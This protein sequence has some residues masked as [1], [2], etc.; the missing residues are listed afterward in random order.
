MNFPSKGKFSPLGD[1]F[2]L[3]I[4]VPFPPNGQF[5]HEMKG[6]RK[7][8]FMAHEKIYYDF[9]PRGKIY[10]KP[11]FFA[12]KD[13]MGRLYMYGQNGVDLSFSPCFAC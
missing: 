3:L 10:L 8:V 9:P 1:N 7:G 4:A 2:P 11:F 5:S 12:S 6:L 13:V